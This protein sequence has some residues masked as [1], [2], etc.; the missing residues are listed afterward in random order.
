MKHGKTVI[1]DVMGVQIS[2]LE[3][4]SDGTLLKH[5]VWA[6]EC[7]EAVLTAVKARTINDILKEVE[8]KGGLNAEQK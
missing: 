4:E 3:D 7:L 1:D 5:V 6:I 2:G 8:H